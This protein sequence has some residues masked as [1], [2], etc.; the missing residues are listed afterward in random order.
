MDARPKLRSINRRY[1]STECCGPE[2][3]GSIHKTYRA[4]GCSGRDG[5]GKAYGLAE[6]RSIRRDCGRRGCEHETR[7]RGACVRVYGLA[8][9]RRGRV[10]G[11]EVRVSCVERGNRVRAYSEGSCSEGSLTTSIQHFRS[12]NDTPIFEG[13]L[14]AGHA[15][16]LRAH[17]CC[18]GERLAELRR[19]ASHGQ[20][21]ANTARGLQHLRRNRTRGA[22][23]EICVS[24][25]DGG[26]RVAPRL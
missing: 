7:E 5:S 2:Q 23:H 25:V 15:G 22:A 21:N 3:R 17:C 11:R 20:S 14:P 8:E 26:D 6:Q 4:G 12:Q 18:E 13:D 16:E 10:A 24:T 19:I 1:A 9:R